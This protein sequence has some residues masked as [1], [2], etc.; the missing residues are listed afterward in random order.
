[1]RRSVAIPILVVGLL[2]VGVSG[3]LAKPPELVA[4]GKHGI[5]FGRGMRDLAA[6]GIR[7]WSGT[8]ARS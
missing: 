4:G 7:S 8:T 2:S 6:A 3:A 1:M 5:V